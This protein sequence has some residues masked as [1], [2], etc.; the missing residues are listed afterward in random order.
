M[1]LTLCASGALLSILGVLLLNTAETKAATFNDPTWPCLQR[2]VENLSLGLMWS[3]PLD[4]AESSS[5][6]PPQANDLAIRLSLRRISLEEA[7]P[8]VSAF[9]ETRPGADQHLMGR[10]FK[11]VFDKLNSDRKRIITGIESYSLK[12]IALAKKIDDT[13]KKMDTMMA[14]STPDYDEIDRLEE[15]LDWDERIYRDRTK[16]LTYVCETPVLLEKRLY[17]IAK[18][19]SDAAPK[20]N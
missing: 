5:E 8:M 11:E 10:I 15:Q 13:R 3:G 16:S 12:Q 9:V 4:D 17:G 20:S 7:E 18:I 1:R 14:A 6:L 2:K 19:L